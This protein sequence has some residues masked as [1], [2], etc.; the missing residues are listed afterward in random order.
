MADIVSLE[1]LEKRI[2]ALEKTPLTEDRVKE[3]ISAESGT[4]AN[5]AVKTFA[6]SDEGK[7]VIGA[8]ASRITSEALA[9]VGTTPV[10]PAPASA[11]QPTIKELVAAGKHEEAWAASEELQKEFSDAK[12]YAA[13]AKGVASGKIANR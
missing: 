12:L 1:S 5:A 4:A 2:A 10:K 9:S 7:K 3:L 8:E 6:A 13:Y 11:Q